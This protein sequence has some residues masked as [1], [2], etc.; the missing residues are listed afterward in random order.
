MK[1]EKAGTAVVSTTASVPKAP[2]GLPLTGMNVW[3]K[4]PQPWDNLALYRICSTG[5]KIPGLHFVPHHRI[6]SHFSYNCPALCPQ[7]VIDI[8]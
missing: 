7:C 5:Y 1:G 6:Y 8:R 2:N 4:T 3:Y